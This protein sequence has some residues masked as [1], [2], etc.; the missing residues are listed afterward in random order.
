MTDVAHLRSQAS[1]LR[2]QAK[3]ESDPSKRD[4]L[5]SLADY[6]DVMAYRMAENE[7]L[8]PRVSSSPL[9]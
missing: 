6:Y 2:A 8:A 7:A 3:T 1:R 4:Q 5:L 9:P